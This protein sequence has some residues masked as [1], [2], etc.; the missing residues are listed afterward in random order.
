MA[1]FEQRS[2]HFICKEQSCRSVL[3]FVYYSLSHQCGLSAE[4]NYK[5][6]K[7]AAS[8]FMYFFAQQTTKTT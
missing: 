4:E 5:S 3:F 7:L 6:F 2:E 8:A 1:S